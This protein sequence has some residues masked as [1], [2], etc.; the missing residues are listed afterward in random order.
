MNREFSGRQLYSDSS[1]NEA[2]LSQI[3]EKAG[4]EPSFFERQTGA[5]TA[6]EKT[7]RRSKFDRLQYRMAGDEAEQNRQH[8]A[9]LD[10]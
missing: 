5:D 10:A 3:F 1:F 2:W 6:L 8:R 9:E 4:I 7:V